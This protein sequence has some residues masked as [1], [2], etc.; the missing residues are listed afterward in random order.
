MTKIEH[1]ILR[2]TDCSIRGR[3]IV[4]ELHPKFMQ[5]RTKSQKVSYEI[6]YEELFD[7]VSRHCGD[8]QIHGEHQEPEE[9]S[10]S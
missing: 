4:V 8:S 7:Y 9:Q 10:Q 5:I 3:I 1:A 6:S 2:E